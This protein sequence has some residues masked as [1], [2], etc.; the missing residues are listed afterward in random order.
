MP[1]KGSGSLWHSLSM[2]VCHRIASSCPVAGAE[3]KARARRLDPGHVAPP[4]CRN[5]TDSSM[6]S[7]QNKKGS[8]LA[9]GF[10]GVGRQFRVIIFQLPSSWWLDWWSGLVA[11]WL[12]IGFPFAFYEK[13]QRVGPVQP[14]RL[15]LTREPTA[16]VGW[17]VSHRIHLAGLTSNILRMQVTKSSRPKLCFKGISVASMES[18]GG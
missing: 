12:R 13:R 7:G 8:G 2:C 15:L 17:Q 16:A 11:W 6:G 3:G 10:F 9:L 5:V 4:C 18:P 14:A 1:A